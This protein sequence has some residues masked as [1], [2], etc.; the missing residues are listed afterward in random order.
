M[1]DL[2]RGLVG[3]S[4][5]VAINE[6]GD[7]VGT[8]QGECAELGTRSFV[9]K[10]GDASAPTPV[11]PGCDT[12]VFDINDTGKMLVYKTR[13]GPFLLENGILT[14]FEKPGLGGQLFY[15]PS[16]LNNRDEAVGVTA[17]ATSTSVLLTMVREP[18]YLVSGKYCWA[19]DLNDRSDIAYSCN[20]A[21]GTIGGYRFNGKLE[22]LAAVG[23]TV[24][25]AAVNNQREIVGRLEGAP[26]GIKLF[27]WVSGVMSVIEPSDGGW[28]FDGVSDLNDAGV[29]LA[30][31]RN[32]STGEVGAVLLTPLP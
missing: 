29:I 4:K 2:G 17:G 28:Q 13:A 30:H 6:R 18:E 8:Y 23:T 9:W 32:R 22:R 25:P 16:V 27:H 21:S 15:H 31:G 5:A 3:A 10:A 12:Q 19:V 1:V 14:Q 11:V 24:E 20:Y 26:G 7:V